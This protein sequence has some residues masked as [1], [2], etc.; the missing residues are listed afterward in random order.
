MTI[1]K[2]PQDLKQALL[3]YKLALETISPEHYDWRK[4]WT[5]LPVTQSIL[6]SRLVRDG[7]WREGLQ[8][9]LNSVRHLS[10]GEDDLAYAKALFEIGRTY[11]TELSDWNNARLYYRDALRFIQAP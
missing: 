7:Q 8:L 10:S 9:L 3:A 2:S 11:D 1:A 6:G 4:I 5:A